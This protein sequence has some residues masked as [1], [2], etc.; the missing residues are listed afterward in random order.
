VSA[1]ESFSQPPSLFKD[2][3]KRKP[4]KSSWGTFI[5]SFCLASNSH[6]PNKA[7]FLVDGGASSGLA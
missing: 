1:Y 3:L 7:K 5:K 2:G 4:I 6:L